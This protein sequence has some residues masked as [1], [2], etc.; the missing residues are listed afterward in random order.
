MRP[1]SS[2][3]RRRFRSTSVRSASGASARRRRGSRGGHR[4]ATSPAEEL[5]HRVD[6]RDRR[7]RSPAESPRRRGDRGRRGQ[8]SRAEVEATGSDCRSRRASPANVAEP[9]EEWPAL[10]DVAPL[11]VVVAEEVAEAGRARRQRRDAGHEAPAPVGR[12]ASRRNRST[13]KK[14]GRRGSGHGPRARKIVGL[15]IG[16]S[17]IAASVVAQT[18]AGYELLELARRPLAG[19]IVV[20]GEVRDEDALVPRSR[21]S[22]TRRSCPE[23]T[24]ASGSRATGSACDDRHRWVRRRRTVRQRRSVQGARGASGLPARVRARLPRDRGASRR[25]R[26]ARATCPSRRRTS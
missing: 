3:P 25:G 16:A 20:D 9:G 1:R 12:F 5:V 8:C 24:F 4:R 22:S 15:K 21:R 6:R 14:A 13:E 11:P 10:E 17:Q 26:R 7:S 2:S 23:T 19:G 18:D